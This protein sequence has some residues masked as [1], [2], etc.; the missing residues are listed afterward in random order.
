[1]FDKPKYSPVETSEVKVD[2]LAEALTRH[3]LE[4]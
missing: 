3:W 2:G 4:A 1:M